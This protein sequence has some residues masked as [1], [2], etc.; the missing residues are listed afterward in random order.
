MSVWWRKCLLRQV[1]TSLA[2]EIHLNG[3]VP[4]TLQ[5]VHLLSVLM[6]KGF[7]Y[8]SSRFLP[9]DVLLRWAL[10]KLLDLWRVFCTFCHCFFSSSLQLF[11]LLPITIII[12]NYNA[13][14]YQIVLV[15]SYCGYVFFSISLTC[16]VVLLFMITFVSQMW[17]E[18]WKC[19]LFH[20]FFKIKIPLICS[21]VSCIWIYFGCVDHVGS[22]NISNLC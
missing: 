21:I 10:P 19:L 1:S 14:T 7:A 13:C 11:C 9:G 4:T 15:I 8:R 3:I 16:F 2:L 20:L 18:K 5:L 22:L 6:G 17:D 12:T